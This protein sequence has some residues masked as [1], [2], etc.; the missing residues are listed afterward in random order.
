MANSG[1]WFDPATNPPP[2]LG[3]PAKV[4]VGIH[5]GMSV[6][7]RF[8]IGL[9]GMGIVLVVAGIAAGNPNASAAGLA[10]LLVGWFAAM[11]VEIS[12]QPRRG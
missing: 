8:A 7:R 6:T 3:A 9:V 1:A 11:T 10:I 4:G 2:I 5:E 12:R